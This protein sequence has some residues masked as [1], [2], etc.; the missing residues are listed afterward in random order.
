M[1]FWLG[2]TAR[3]EMIPA[4]FVEPPWAEGSC[5]LY[6]A[7]CEMQA[8]I[9]ARE[10]R[11][12]LF[13]EAN[14]CER[15]SALDF[16]EFA[17]D[18]IEGLLLR[19]G[20]TDALTNLQRYAESVRTGLEAV[21]EA[22]F[23]RLRGEV[24]SGVCTG[25]ALRRRIADLAGPATP[26]GGQP[27]EGYDALDALVNGILLEESAPE[28]VGQPEPEMIFYQPTPARIVLEMVERMDFRPDDI[29]YDIGSG[30]G[31][32]AI[33]VHLLTGVQTRGVEIEPAYADYARRCAEGLNLPAVQ[34][35]RGDARTA[36]YANGSIFF[37]YTPFTGQ[38]LDQ[39]LER[40]RQVSTRQQIRLCTFGPCTPQVDGQLWLQPLDQTSL[41]ENRLALWKST[42]APAPWGRTR[43][44]R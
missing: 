12:V 20:E 26:G 10:N 24:A 4:V 43:T 30:L 39:V 22:L 17:I 35:I 23:R 40:L 33:L 34:F 19:E 1:R 36:A 11:P 13:A 15:S 25:D 21:D 7:I 44:I 32:V 27:A 3:G 42:P 29:F 28:N 38:M 9:E 31:Q 18:R 8:S 16:L 41:H 2:C 37:L 6:N 14:F 5:Q